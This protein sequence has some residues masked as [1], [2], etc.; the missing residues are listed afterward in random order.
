MQVST[1]NLVFLD[2]GHGNSAVLETD[3]RVVIIDT[4]PG[5]GLLEHLK[6]R[7]IDTVDLVLISHADED[8]VGALAQLLA[9]DIIQVNNVYL[10]TD[11]LKDSKTWLDLTYELDRAHNER[12]LNFQVQLTSDE[13]YNFNQGNVQIEVLGPSKMLAARGPGSING[14]GRKL[15]SN[16]ISAVFRIAHNG[17]H[18]AVLPGDLDDIGLDSLINRNESAKARVLVFPHHGSKPSGTNVDDFVKKLSQYFDPEIIIFS[19]GRGK[20]GTPNPEVLA[21]LRKCMPRIRIICT[22]LSE[23]CAKTL[24][25]GEPIHLNRSYSRGRE[26]NSC[27]GGS[28]VISLDDQQDI[29]PDEDI[30]T[31]FIRESAPA[32]LCIPNALP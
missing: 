8:H 29:A 14:D 22:Q 25:T 32:A 18:I 13:A 23:H 28:I 4:G 17:R 31:A 16:S 24:P 10:N 26:E 7:S 3:T 1:P 30:H 15:T 20:Y 19:I 5:S 11:S 12:G 2:I 9:S 21:T 27:C 6:D